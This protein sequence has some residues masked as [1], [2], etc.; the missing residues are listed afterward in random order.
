MPPGEYE[1]ASR[2]QPDR[3]ARQRRHVCPSLPRH[4]PLDLV[5]EDLDRGVERV[6]RDGLS[7]GVL[8]LDADT[9][10]GGRGVVD[11]EPGA[12]ERQRLRQHLAAA[13]RRSHGNE[14]IRPQRQ[15][16]QMMRRLG[17]AP[18]DVAGH[19]ARAGRYDAEGRVVRA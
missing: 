7:R 11:L 15:T 9:T 2:P 12:A 8:K 1:G 4:V 18:L 17:V 10:G 16:L 3:A 19:L 13:V 6:A 5:A 14:T